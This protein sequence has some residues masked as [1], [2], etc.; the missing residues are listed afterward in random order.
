LNKNVFFT[1][2]L[3][4]NF[5]KWSIYNINPGLL[6]YIHAHLS[7]KAHT[8]GH[9]LSEY[10]FQYEIWQFLQLLH[11][12]TNGIVKRESDGKV[13]LVIDEKLEGA[14]SPKIFYELKTYI[15]PTENKIAPVKIAEDMQKLAYRLQA[16]VNLVGDALDVTAYQ[17][18]IARRNALINQ[19]KVKNKNILNYKIQCSFFNDLAS[20]ARSIDNLDKKL[21][22]RSQ[23]TVDYL[24]NPEHNP[25][26]QVN[27]KIIIR[28]SIKKV[29][30]SY[31][32]VFVEVKLKGA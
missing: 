32:V 29:D 25:K 30:K 31:A 18:I 3:I 1:P 12:N 4:R 21:Q 7:L 17:I 5:R 23:Y 19:Q 2:G 10:D 22:F 14:S 15:K 9:F 16:Q 8:T 20:Y 24:I 13:D 26:M 6:R 28:P 27:Q 11:K